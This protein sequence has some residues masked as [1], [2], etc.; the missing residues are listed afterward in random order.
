MVM[1][2]RWEKILV[3]VL[4]M[5]VLSGCGFH[6]QA[7][8]T[9]KEKVKREEHVKSEP[10]IPVLKLSDALSSTNSS[11][12]VEAGTYSWNYKNGN[13]ISGLTACGSHPLE[14]AQLPHT[15]KLEI[16]EYNRM[17]KVSYMLSCKV[18]PDV[19]KVC[20]WDAAD[21]GNSK[22]AIQSKDIY[23]QPIFLVE[24]EPGYVYEFTATWKKEKLEENGFYGEASY[25]FV[26]ESKGK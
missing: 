11:F 16:P 19:L 21:I 10:S 23:R 17:E 6:L 9:K 14:S 5:A 22:A 18:E 2:L 13:D 24:L 7:P 15:A 8:K 12:K 4:S 3:L 26:T 20:K 25:V 1:K